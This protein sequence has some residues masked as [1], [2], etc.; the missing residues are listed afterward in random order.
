M[1]PVVIERRVLTWLLLGLAGAGLPALR[2]QAAP[3]P[4]ATPSLVLVVQNGQGRDLPNAR[5]SLDGAPPIEHVDGQLVSVAPGEHRLLFQAEGF[6]PIEI[7]VLAREGQRKLRVLV[8]L[9]PAVGGGEPSRR[10]PGELPLDLAAPSSPPPAWSL[11]GVEARPTVPSWRKR[12]A[13]TL[14]GA[15][16]GSLVIGTVWAFLAKAKYDHALTTECGGRSDSCSPQGIADGRSAHDRAFVSTLGFAGAGIFL[17]GAETVY[18][19]WPATN[20]RV[21]LAP[22]ITDRGAGLAFRW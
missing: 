11:A 21:A 10:E 6:N 20:E 4:A 2:A 14:L 7:T 1:V 3:T 13:G 22:T 15:A 18:F 9:T 5:M 8:F 12:V 19:A 17:A 16:A